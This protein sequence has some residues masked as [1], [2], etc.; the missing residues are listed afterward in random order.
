MGKFQ[1]ASGVKL[2]SHQ[3][4]EDYFRMDRLLGDC[5]RGESL[6][7]NE[8]PMGILLRTMLLGE[9]SRERRVRPLTRG[10]SGGIPYLTLFYSRF[11]KLA[12]WFQTPPGPRPLI[13]SGIS[14]DFLFKFGI[15]LHA[16]RDGQL[17]EELYALL[18]QKDAEDVIPFLRPP[19]VEASIYIGFQILERKPFTCRIIHYFEPGEPSVYYKKTSAL[20]YFQPLDAYIGPPRENLNV[21]GFFRAHTSSAFAPDLNRLPAGISGT[22]PGKKVVFKQRGLPAIQGRAICYSIRSAGENGSPRI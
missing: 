13:G 14:P 19:E 18:E 5:L 2:Y 6:H 4:K 20:A 10:D 9:S 22:V 17:L 15:V 1:S 11:L 8:E 7:V 12:P 16:E 3:V 21:E